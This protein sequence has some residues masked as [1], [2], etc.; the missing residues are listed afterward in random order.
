M[1]LL[2]LSRLFFL[3]SAGQ[4]SS[5]RSHFILLS[6]RYMPQILVGESFAKIKEQVERYQEERYLHCPQTLWENGRVMILLSQERVDSV[7]VCER[8]ESFRFRCNLR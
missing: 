7:K 5:I 6:R 3:L 1:H 8:L 4:V 2:L